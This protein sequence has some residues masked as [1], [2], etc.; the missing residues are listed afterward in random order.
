M[1]YVDPR[2][3]ACPDEAVGWL[4]IFLTC[5]NRKINPMRNKYLLVKKKLLFI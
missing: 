5:N 1:Q 2:P 4:A 3:E